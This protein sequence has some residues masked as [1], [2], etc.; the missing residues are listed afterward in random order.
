VRHLFLFII[1]SLF[2]LTTSAQNR[3]DVPCSRVSIIPPLGG[4]VKDHFS[5]IDKIYF[6][7]MTIIEHAGDVDPTLRKLDS[8]AW[9]SKGVTVYDQF[10]M[11]INGYKGQ[12]LY[13]KLS[14]RMDAITLAFGDSVFF[15]QIQAN[16]LNQYKNLYNEIIKSFETIKF[17]REKEIDWE[18][19]FVFKYNNQNAF[20]LQEE[21][22]SPLLF[23]FLKEAVDS[24]TP[25]TSYIGIQQVPNEG[26]PRNLKSFM[27]EMI[28]ST[29]L[30]QYSI[31][32][33]IFDGVIDHNGKQAY[34]FDIITQ[35]KDSVQHLI[36][37]LGHINKKYAV[38][39]FANI[40]DEKDKE[41]TIEFL[42]SIEFKED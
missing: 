27:A 17:N 30:P 42:N 39:I 9:A 24:L 5:I 16:Y 23:T 36:K 3:I 1:I 8:A 34:S 32:E 28:A 11:D 2:S 40:S 31:E 10:E 14:P 25:K 4:E 18:S 12:C 37:C 29:V 33:V 7:E 13:K 19:D 26:N 21:Y 41:D 22:I 38:F 15:V 20:K 6:F 35:K